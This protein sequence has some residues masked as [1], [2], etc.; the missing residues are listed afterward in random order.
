MACTDD[1]NDKRVTWLT[2]RTY[3]PS[4]N[5]EARWNRSLSL[6]LVCAIYQDRCVCVTVSDMVC[7]HALTQMLNIDPELKAQA[8]QLS[9]YLSLS[10]PFSHSIN[11]YIYTCLLLDMHYKI[12]VMFY[13]S[14]DRKPEWCIKP[15]RQA[16]QA[17]HHTRLVKTLLWGGRGLPAK[18]L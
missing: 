11:I 10:L 16:H 6:P 4:E 7:L 1:T 18:D 17:K 15:Y 8:Q 12:I 9:P 14:C 13:I 3:T 2:L 5:E